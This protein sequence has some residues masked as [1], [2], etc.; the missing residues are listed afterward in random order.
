[1]TAAVV[2]APEPVE[3]HEHEC[4]MCGSAP[5]YRHPDGP[6]YCHYCASF[7]RWETGVKCAPLVEAQSCG[8]PDGEDPGEGVCTW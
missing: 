8:T 1:M 3:D 6:V 4:A 7:V 5:D 2:I